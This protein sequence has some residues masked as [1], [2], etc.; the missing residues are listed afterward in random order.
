MVVKSVLQTVVQTADATVVESVPQG[1]ILLALIG[2]GSV[3]GDGGIVGERGD[4]GA[5]QAG[6][7]RAIGA[8][9]A[10]N[11]SVLELVL[12]HLE[13]VEQDIAKLDLVLR[14]EAVVAT[15]RPTPLVTRHIRSRRASTAFVLKRINALFADQG[16]GSGGIGGRFVCDSQV[17]EATDGAGK[18]IA[19]MAGR[20][21]HN[22]MSSNT[23]CRLWPKRVK[24]QSQGENLRAS[25][26]MT[27]H[28][29]P[30]NF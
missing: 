8:Q 6:E 20:R 24:H 29:T 15:F 18:L 1:L 23:L 28:A 26:Y 12:D 11:G 10:G 19:S 27:R 14:I 25:S 13:P 17:E 16:K 7:G 9:V 21:L 4:K 3:D 5:P 22:R 2:G 30:I